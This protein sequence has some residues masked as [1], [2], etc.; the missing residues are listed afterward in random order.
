MDPSCRDSGVNR[1]D[2][3]MWVN[4]SSLAISVV[5]ENVGSIAEDAS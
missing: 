5:I 1:Q 4:A 3:T 2:I